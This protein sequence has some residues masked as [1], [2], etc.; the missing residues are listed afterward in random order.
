KNAAGTA[1]KRLTVSQNPSTSGART[2]QPE[3]QSCARNTVA[4]RPRPS[5]R[6]IRYWLPS[7]FV[8]VSRTDNRC[9]RTANERGKAPTRPRRCPLLVNGLLVD[10]SAAGWSTFGRANPGRSRMHRLLGHS[11]AAVVL[12]FGIRGGLTAPPPAAITDAGLGA[13]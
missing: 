1:L 11:A 9:L 6:S 3:W 8:S 7:A 4:N 12:A 13:N 10:R 5:S 2:A